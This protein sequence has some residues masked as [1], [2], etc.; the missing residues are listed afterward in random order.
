M[1]RRRAFITGITG[2]AGS[3]LAEEL[4]AHGWQVTGS[5]QWGEAKHN[6]EP[7]RN[8]ISLVSFDLRDATGMR[9][10]IRTAKPTHIFHLAAIASV[11]QSLNAERATYESNFGG[12]LNLLELAADIPTLEKL[13]IVSSSEVYGQAARNAARLTETTSL[14]PSSPYAIAKAAA[15]QAALF[16]QRH[17]GLPVVIARAFNHTG[18]RQSAIFVAPS[19][20]RQIAAIERGLQKPEILVGDLSVRRDLSCVTDIVRGYRLAAER[21]VP[22]EVYHLCSGKV[23]PIRRVLDTLVKMSAQT[24]TVSVDPAKIRRQEIPVLGGSRAKAAKQLG[25]RPKVTLE[26]CL[27][28]TLD[29]W[30]SLP[31]KVYE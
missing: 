18:P 13:L 27:R 20:A 26:Q 31:N 7:F 28:K 17:R 24:I 21:G 25:W 10:V 1:T 14:N 16:A 5:R 3:H 15:D 29:Y 6:I 11:S 12:T 4:L 9:S 2:F 30:R 23:V 8:K 22:G 19:F